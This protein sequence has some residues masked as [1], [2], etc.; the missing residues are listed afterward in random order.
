MTSRWPLQRLSTTCS[1]ASSSM[2]SVTPCCL[3]SSTICPDTSVGNENRHNPPL[4]LGTVGRGEPRQVLDLQLEGPPWID[5]LD[6]LSVAALEPRAQAFVSPHDLVQRL[7]E[8][9][10]VQ[11]AAQ[12]QRHRHVV[13]PVCRLHLFEEPEPL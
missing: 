10:H 7:P 9:R 5:R 2:Y 8:R 4:K 1:A 3:A 12:A 11:T 6:G 13:G